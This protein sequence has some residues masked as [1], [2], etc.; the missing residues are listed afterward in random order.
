MLHKKFIG[1]AKNIVHVGIAHYNSLPWKTEI[2]GKTGL[3]RYSKMKVN[4]KNHNYFL[5]ID[6]D[7]ECPGV[8]NDFRLKLESY[9]MEDS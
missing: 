6:D 7:K 1:E 5:L 2:E 8:E 4:L 3:V 9:L